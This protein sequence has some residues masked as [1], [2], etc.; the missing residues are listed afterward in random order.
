MNGRAAWTKCPLPD[1]AV[2]A[3]PAGEQA[4]MQSPSTIVEHL[5]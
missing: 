1:I 4:S 5:N 2:F 3:A